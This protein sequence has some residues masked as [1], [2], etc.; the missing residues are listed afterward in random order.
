MILCPSLQFEKRMTNEMVHAYE[1]KIEVVKSKLEKLAN[2][3]MQK[4]RVFMPKSL[5][6]FEKESM[7][8]I[9]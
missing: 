8:R 6:D 4:Q 9:I 1:G 2:E 5:G 3:N 7:S